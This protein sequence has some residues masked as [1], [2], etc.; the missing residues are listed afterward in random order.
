MLITIL[1]L[2]GTQVL[3]IGKTVG[4]SALAGLASGDASRKVKKRFPE[5]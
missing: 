2:G 3:T 1:S 4:L 5:M